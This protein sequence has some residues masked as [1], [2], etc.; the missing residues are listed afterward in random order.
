[1]GIKKGAKK[2]VAVSDDDDRKRGLRLSTMV[3]GKNNDALSLVLS[4]IPD[5]TGATGGKKPATPPIPINT[6]AAYVTTVDSTPTSTNNSHTPQGS[7][8][9]PMTQTSKGRRL[10][11]DSIDFTN[12]PS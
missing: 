8:P 9:L 4:D 2:A 7:T 3:K 10:Q 12:S 11:D 6:A 5:L 1:V